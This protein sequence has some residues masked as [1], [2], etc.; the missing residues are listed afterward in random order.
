MLSA[1]KFT[2]YF[3]EKI[4]YKYDVNM[5]DAIKQNESKLATFSDIAKLKKGKKFL[6]FLF[7][8]NCNCLY[9]WN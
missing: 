4:M 6:C 8:T 2:S 5:C 1:R 7:Y 3:W 9:P